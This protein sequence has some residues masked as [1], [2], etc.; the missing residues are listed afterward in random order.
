MRFAWEKLCAR[1]KE[2][3]HK[4]LA[5]YRDGWRCRC[6]KSYWN[7]REMLQKDVCIHT[8]SS[9]V[10]N[11]KHKNNAMCDDNE[12]ANK[13]NARKRKNPCAVESK[14]WQILKNHH[15]YCTVCTL[16]RV[17]TNTHTRWCNAMFPLQEKRA[18]TH[19]QS[20]LVSSFAT[21]RFS[22]EW[23]WMHAKSVRE[24]YAA[25]Q[26]YSHIIF[27]LFCAFA[28]VCFAYCSIKIFSLS[29][30]R[31]S[32]LFICLLFWIHPSFDST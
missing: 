8:L 22:S 12:R 5:V 24:K 9:S 23:W 32:I 18:R 1:H 28:V 14:Q 27:P 6:R 31:A 13:K 21:F 17:Q 10:S 26:L 16:C 30:R 25:L 3:K 2:H 11:I 29:L 20:R 7:F 15:D 4:K 19:I